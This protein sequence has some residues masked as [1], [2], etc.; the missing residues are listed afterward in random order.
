MKPTYYET[1]A[2]DWRTRLIVDIEKTRFNWTRDSTE[3]R[4]MDSRLR[5][6]TKYT[7]IDAV[8]DLQ[9]YKNYVAAFAE[10][11]NDSPKSLPSQYSSCGFLPVGV[12]PDYYAG[13]INHNYIIPRL[14]ELGLEYFLIVPLS[15][16]SS[17][18]KPIGRMASQHD[19]WVNKLEAAK[20]I[21]NKSAHN[22]TTLD[23]LEVIL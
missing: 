4:A 8:G 21:K 9:A 22:I 7:D 23:L 13:A 19:V 1:K 14:V 2:F 10:I 20:V 12:E 16:V 5:I 3:G 11:T 17:S 18:Y 15:P 6:I